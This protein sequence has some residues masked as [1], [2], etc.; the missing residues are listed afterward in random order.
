MNNEYGS[1]ERG[2]PFQVFAEDGSLPPLRM[3]HLLMFLSTQGRS[4]KCPHCEWN[5]GW[6][7]AL[8]EEADDL[9]DESGFFNPR[10]EI[11]THGNI[12]GGTRTTV[13]MT[14]PNCGSF[15]EISTYKIREMLSKDHQGNG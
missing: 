1:A 9:E 7:I 6:E 5:G 15:S 14:C 4:T 10:L 12:R 3:S 11:I 8:H 2:G 13:A